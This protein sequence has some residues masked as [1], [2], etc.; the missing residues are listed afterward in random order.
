MLDCKIDCKKHNFENSTKIFASDN[1]TL[2]RMGLF[3]VAQGWG[4]QKAPLSKICHTYPATMKLGTLISYLK[5]IRKTYKSCD[6]PL[7]FC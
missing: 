5:K 4:W 2:F 1:L 6:T 3:G 7:D